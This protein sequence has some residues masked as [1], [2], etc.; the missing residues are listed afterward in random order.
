M[1][2]LVSFILTVYGTSWCG[3]CSVQL[4]ELN[5][6]HIPF[7]YKDVTNADFKASVPLLV[8]DRGMVH[9]GLLTGQALKDFANA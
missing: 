9:E 3:Y 6:L 4:D 8:N 7:L 2:Y 1:K 5:A